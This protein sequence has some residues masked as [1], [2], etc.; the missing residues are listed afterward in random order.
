MYLQLHP[1]TCTLHSQGHLPPPPVIYHTWFLLLINFTSFL[2]YPT[3]DSHHFS[4]IKLESIGVLFRSFVLTTTAFS[5]FIIDE[6]QMYVRM[7]AT[8]ITSPYSWYSAL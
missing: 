4:F 3:L 2:K 7:S 6:K 8:S 1:F 5:L